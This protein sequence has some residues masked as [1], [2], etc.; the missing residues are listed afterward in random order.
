[1]ILTLSH[2]IL[3]ASDFCR[4]IGIIKTVWK[5]LDI[6]LTPPFFSGRESFFKI[7]W[8]FFFLWPI[9]SLSLSYYMNEKHYRGPVSY[10]IIDYVAERSAEIKKVVEGLT[11]KPL[12][13]KTFWEFFFVQTPEGLQIRGGKENRARLVYIYLE[14]WQAH[15]G[16]YSSHF[17]GVHLT[18]EDL[19]KIKP[20]FSES[21]Q[22]IVKSL[23][24]LWNV[25]YH[26][27]Q[28]FQGDFW[29][30]S[31]IREDG[32]Q[33]FEF[34]W[35][36]LM[37]EG[38]VFS[39]F[40]LGDIN[41]PD[42][43]PEIAN[44]PSPF[45][46][47]ARGMIR[48]FAKEGFAPAQH[49]EAFMNMVFYRDLNAALEWFKQSYR[50]GYRRDVSSSVLG[51]FYRRLQPHR[52]DKA[53]HYLKEAIYTHDY[54]I[55]NYR[56]LKGELLELYIETGRLNEAVRVA[57][58][59]AENFTDFDIPVFLQGMQWLSWYFYNRDNR[60]LNSLKESYTWME[61]ARIAAEDYGVSS[62]LSRLEHS[63]PLQSSLTA[64][65]RRQIKLK[66]ANLYE[67]RKYLLTADSSRVCNPLLFKSGTV[68]TV[69]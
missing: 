44:N 5:F 41:N 58:E 43:L 59:I 45:F 22:H 37:I 48:K 2:V 18:K 30:L 7:L 47:K 54:G 52:L 66:A 38:Q 10:Q 51:V 14:Q 15:S 26:P 21:E 63:L 27:I 35:A 24:F 67:A 61:M 34:L 39:Y 50:K 32:Y 28:A 42:S 20:L 6:P 16:G 29:D 68:E 9:P 13:A 8:F 49:L 1:M 23:T 19:D 65:Q 4:K 53:E 36:F 3:K 25:R 33:E 69:H 62:H 55:H 17:G 12:D 56:N 11:G 46:R 31:K 64:E 40:L 60:N 57:R